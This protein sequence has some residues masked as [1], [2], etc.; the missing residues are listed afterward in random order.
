MSPELW[1]AAALGAGVL[2]VAWRAVDG[3]LRSKARAEKAARVG[4]RLAE[5]V[6]KLEME[7]SKLPEDAVSSG[8]LEELQAAVENAKRTLITREAAEKL[9]DRVNVVSM[10][11]L[12]LKEWQ[13]S[14][15]QTGSLEDA[16]LHG[17]KEKL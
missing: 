3:H 8:Q 10:D 9:V 11:V 14:I 6:A 12:A 5:R 7:L 16:L 13:Q 17:A 2:A 1:V 4:S 15:E